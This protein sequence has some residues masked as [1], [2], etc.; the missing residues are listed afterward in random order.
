VG[1][2]TVLDSGP[3]GLVTKPRGKPDGDASRARLDVLV[4]AGWAIAVPEIADYEVR[5]ELIRARA[6][7]GLRRLDQFNEGVVYLPMTTEVMHMAA[8]LWAHV[9]N[10]HQPTA[11]DKAL[12]GDCIVSAIALLA[13]SVGDRVL[14]ATENSRHLSRFP[15]VDAVS[16]AEID[17]MAAVYMSLRFTIRFVGGP[18]DGND[19]N[20]DDDD[21]TKAEEAKM[22]FS[23]TERGEV[24]TRFK[25]LSPYALGQ[26]TASVSHMYQVISNRHSEGRR[27]IE[28]EYQG[29]S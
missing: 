27:V 22:F 3:L 17:A 12:D 21:P 28:I 24:G 23:F 11:D 8:K 13:S 18:Y 10:T 16:W 29:T 1:L 2:L 19:L 25:G 4:A 5:R 26:P 9:R 6:T 20:G 14:V 15:G 7:A